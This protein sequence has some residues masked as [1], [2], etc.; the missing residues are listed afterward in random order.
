MMHLKWASIQRVKDQ[1]WSGVC[2]GMNHNCVGPVSVCQGL[3][4]VV[5]DYDN[6]QSHYI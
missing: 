2:S 4:V 3:L 6:I 5:G 1:V